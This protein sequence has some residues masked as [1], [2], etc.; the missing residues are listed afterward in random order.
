M[1]AWLIHQYGGNNELALYD[2]VRTPTI[3]SPNELLIKVYA[4]S[5]N[6][7]DVKMRSGYGKKLLKLLRMQQTGL[8]PGSEFPLI[9]GRDFSGVVVETGQAVKNFKP[10]DEIWGALG[11]HKQGTHAQFT[12]ASENEIS[13]KPE[14]LT[15]IEAASIPY[16]ALTSWAALCSVGELSEKNARR[17]RILVQGG[18]G[19]IGSFSIQLLKAW[20]AHVTATCST[21][22]VE[23]VKNLGADVVI[24]YKTQNA[25]K[26]LSRLKPY[27][28]V[29]DTVGG[30][31][32]DYSFDLLAT[33][34]NAKLVTIITPLLKNADTFGYVPG[35]AKSAFSLG[36]N[37]LKGVTGGRHYRWAIFV[38]N[39]YALSKVGHLVQRTEIRPVIEQV[40]PFKELS[41]AYANVEKGHNRGKTVVDMST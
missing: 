5:V 24:D 3:K 38:P 9:L 36:S 28:F 18:S 27:D 1:E 17:K 8:N 4:A 7:I 2:K 31:V 30:Q 14:N 11:A 39:S 23:F 35:L 33:W 40:Y 16:V 22:A 34:K 32:A 10:G 12:V 29:L 25:R 21:D 13:K 15:H 6:P 19:G 41:E 37:L 20:D 26:E